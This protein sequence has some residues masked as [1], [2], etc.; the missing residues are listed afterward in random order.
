MTA[1]QEINVGRRGVKVGLY[2]LKIA[3][4]MC[5]RIRWT[6]GVPTLRDCGEVELGLLLED[7]IPSHEYCI[8]AQKD[9]HT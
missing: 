6:W 4:S 2:K 5:E 7:K 3:G 8:V 1:E 9:V